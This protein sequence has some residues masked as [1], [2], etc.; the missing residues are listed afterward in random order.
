M[1]PGISVL[2]LT[3][4]EERN[5]PACLASLAWCDDIVV[6]DSR[7]TDR[8]TAIAR[9]RGARIVER[10]FTDFADQRNYALREIPFRHSWLFHLDADERFTPALLDECRAAA[11]RDDR[12]GYLVPS[13]MI[14]RGRWLKHA[15]AYPVY[16]MRFLKLG[17]VSFE[18]AGHG[19]R[20]SRAERGLG[21]LSEPYLHESFGSGFE[22]WFDKHNRYST[23]EARARL[24]GNGD[25]PGAARL[26]SSD[27]VE[28][29][30]ALKAFSW[31]LPLRP[32]LK[33]AYLYVLRRGFLD[34]G[35]GLTYC[36][37]QAVYEY[38]IDLKYRELTDAN[39]RLQPLLR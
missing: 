38:S 15:A 35:P 1:T 33:F 11:S 16:Q 32:L 12:S 3:R 18:R 8:T 17:E 25:G 14:L 26:V 22:R 21:M 27:P 23:G 2:I 28:R 29:R 36:L 20:E 30:R 10:A 37:L 9:D 31:R 24:N 4:D 7:S 13:R 6:L 5:L 34:G 39:Q 19:Q